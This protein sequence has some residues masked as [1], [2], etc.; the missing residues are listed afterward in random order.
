MVVESCYCESFEP[1]SLKRI[2]NCLR[3]FFI[4]HGRLYWS[5]W[6]TKVLY[7]Y[8]FFYPISAVH[9][10]NAYSLPVFHPYLA[11]GVV[12]TNT[13]LP[14]Y[15][16]RAQYIS[17]TFSHKWVKLPLA[18]QILDDTF[19]ARTSLASFLWRLQA[20]TTQKPVR[21]NPLRV[22]GTILSNMSLV[23]TSCFLMYT[24]GRE[25]YRSGNLKRVMKFVYKTI[26]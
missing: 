2:Y 16:I 15:A 7:R 26:R 4:E 19:T 11:V 9:V 8:M 10:I 13:L 5:R 14:E 23:L 18:V 1:K 22:N 20:Q 21:V 12:V 6:Y 25:I 24:V 17:V 3:R